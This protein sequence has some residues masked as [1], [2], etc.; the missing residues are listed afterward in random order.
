MEDT[1]ICALRVLSQFILTT[2]GGDRY[3]YRLHFTEGGNRHR[4]L[5]YFAQG[6]RAIVGVSGC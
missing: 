2:A 6:R 1:V 3:Y 4:Q 5:Q